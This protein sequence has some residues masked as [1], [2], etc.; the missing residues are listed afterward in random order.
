MATRQKPPLWDERGVDVRLV[1]LGVAFLAWVVVAGGT[2]DAAF[3]H[4]VGAACFLA[5]MTALLTAALAFGTIA[6]I[7][8][9]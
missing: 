5:S 4:D 7:R 1:A 9:K 8:R 6:L 2:V 3:Q